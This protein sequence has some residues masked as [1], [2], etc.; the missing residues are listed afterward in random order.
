MKGIEWLIS[1]V[2]AVRKAIFCFKFGPTLAKIVVLNLIPK[3]I[4]CFF[5]Y[6]C[7]VQLALDLSNFFLPPRPAFTSA[8]TSAYKYKLSIWI[9][10]I[11]IEICG[12]LVGSLFYFWFVFFPSS[13]KRLLKIFHSTFWNS[14]AKDLFFQYPA[15]ILLNVFP[16][17]CFIGDGYIWDAVRLSCKYQLWGIKFSFI[18][19][20]WCK[21]PVLL[22]FPV[23]WCAL[24]Y[25]CCYIFHFFPHESY[26]SLLILWSSFS[27]GRQVSLTQN[28]D[29]M[30]IYQ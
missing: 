26:F 5:F 23:F 12:K 10:D 3:H 7:K 29:L 17:L 8:F 24:C 16:L 6:H 25:F 30:M 27:R 14:I 28:M 2:L 18:R 1:I 21:L 9:C 13:H 4:N 20:F 19:I 22:Y 15:L 11:I